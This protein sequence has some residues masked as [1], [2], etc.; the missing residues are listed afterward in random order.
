MSIPIQMIGSFSV[1]SS[2]FARRAQLKCS[3]Q[4]L[5]RTY[6]I[7][8]HNRVVL[9]VLIPL[10]LSEGV[11]ASLVV[12]GFRPIWLTDGSAYRTPGQLCMATI[13]R[14]WVI[15]AWSGVK[16]IFDALVLAFVLA[17]L[18]GFRKSSGGT[19]SFIESLRARQV[20]YFALTTAIYL[21][22][23]VLFA[24]DM[25]HGGY[26]I[27]FI[28]ALTSISAQRVI[29]ADISATRAPSEFVAPLTSI[30]ENL[31]PADPLSDE[32]DA[33]P[34]CTSDGDD[35]KRSQMRG[36]VT[37][38]QPRQDPPP[39]L[40]RQWTSLHRKSRAPRPT[41][42]VRPV[43][44]LSAQL[45]D[46]YHARRREEMEGR[47]SGAQEEDALITRHNLADRLERGMLRI[48]NPTPSPPAS[49]DEISM[50]IR[51]PATLARSFSEPPGVFNHHAPTAAA[52]R[53]VAALYAN[54][55]G[56][57]RLTPVSPAPFSEPRSL[58]HPISHDSATE[59]DLAPVLP[60]IQEISVT[61]D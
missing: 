15:G 31:I 58:Q 13:P 55:M 27:S 36:R 46:Q 19:T 16:L 33:Y 17:S 61:S 11:L 51:P 57:S 20:G 50:V 34:A 8:R 12:A 53:R 42:P 9:H 2:A 29:L 54:E 14:P 56:R 18:R 49:L 6:A 4:F 41:I 5:I 40:R 7:C 30:K 43:S 35:E 28:P 1:G 23:T 39:L 48:A 60:Q 44:L 47:L 59:D 26:F 3:L 22:A 45:S 32:P 37:E 25:V 21:T 38:L 10:L 24:T 52:H